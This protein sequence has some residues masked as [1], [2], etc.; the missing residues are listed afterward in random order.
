MDHL[1]QVEI[2][3]ALSEGDVTKFLAYAAIFIFIWIEVRGLKKEV[4]NLSLTITKTFG[5]AEHRFKEIEYRQIKFENELKE[6]I[7]KYKGG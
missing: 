6:L 3:K 2:Y 1:I 4:A 5:E 7:Q